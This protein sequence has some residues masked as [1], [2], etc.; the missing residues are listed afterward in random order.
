MRVCELL[1]FSIERK[2]FDIMNDDADDVDHG[3]YKI[4]TIP[5]GWRAHAHASYM[6]ACMRMC[7]ACFYTRFDVRIVQCSKRARCAA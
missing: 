3:E 4:I 7:A 5:T 1:K 2:H 6:H